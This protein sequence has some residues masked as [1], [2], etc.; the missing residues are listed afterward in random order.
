MFP[1]VA[2]HSP[3]SGASMEGISPLAAGAATAATTASFFLEGS[4]L[5]TRYREK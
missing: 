2:I 4:A 3:N 1:S 5:A